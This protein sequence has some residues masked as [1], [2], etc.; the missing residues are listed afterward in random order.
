MRNLSLMSCVALM[1]VSLPALAQKQV[2]FKNDIHPMLSDYCVSCHQ[3]GGKGFVKSG[4]DLRS[5]KGL[6]AGTK[7]GPVIKAG[8][9]E[10]STLIRLV[11]GHADPSISMPFGMKGGLSKD[12]IT[13]LKHWIDQGAKNN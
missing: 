7:F 9:S 1:L 11:E 4:L 8:D 6:M 12:K 10:S 13:L 5:Y 3:P 2:S